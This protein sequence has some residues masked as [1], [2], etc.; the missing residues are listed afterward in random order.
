MKKFSIE[1]TDLTNFLLS[2]KNKIKKPDHTRVIYSANF[3]SYDAIV[4]PAFVDADIDYI[5]FT[6][7]KD[8]KSEIWNIIY[9]DEIFIDARSTARIIKHMPHKFLEDWERS[10]WIDSQI[11]IN[12]C[13]L[14]SFF[15]KYNEDNFVCFKNWLR[16]RVYLEA[17]SCALKGHASVFSILKQ[18]LKYKYNGFPDD[19]YLLASGVLLRNH[20]NKNNIR[21]QN[22]WIKEV[23]TQTIRDQLSFNY[24]AYRENF[25]FNYFEE[26]F[27]NI[28]T[29]ENHKKHGIYRNGNFK[30]PIQ[31][32]F[33]NLLKF[34]KIK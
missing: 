30:V 10:L 20:M 24:C 12:K 15:N 2:L 34:L 29:L 22:F 5:Y 18:Y 32:S 4:D 17:L 27:F 21:L 26:N 13:S 1:D 23:I 7:N 19:K 3:G 8:A 14:K 9:I 33:Y 16:N 11:R 6:D 28:F 31:R 25:Q